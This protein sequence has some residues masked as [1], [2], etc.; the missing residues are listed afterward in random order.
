M[1]NTLTSLR[2]SSKEVRARVRRK[3]P[4][5]RL[6]VEALEAR[7]VPSAVPGSLDVLATRTAAGP[8]GT[9]YYRVDLSAAH[10]LV[11]YF[12]VDSPFSVSDTALANALT[13][14]NSLT[15]SGIDEALERYAAELPDVAV[16]RAGHDKIGKA[17]VKVDGP[18]AVIEPGT[19]PI[20]LPASV[21]IVAVDLRDLPA[22]DE[23]NE[24]LPQMVVPALATPV[25]QLVHLVRTHDGPKDEVFSPFNVYSTNVGQVQPPPLP[26]TGTRDLPIV[27]IVGEQIAPQAAD[28]AATLRAA[29]RAWIA[30]ESVRLEVA[31]SEWQGIGKDGLAVRT[32]TLINVVDQP[33]TVLPNQ[34]AAQDNP[35]DPATATYR[36]DFTIAPGALAVTVSVDGQAT[37]DLDLFLVHD[38][39]GDGIFDLYSEYVAFGA[40]GSA[41]ETVYLASP[42]AGNYEVFVHGYSVPSGTTTFTLAIGMT[43]G[44]PLPDELQPDLAVD[45]ILGSNGTTGDDRYAALAAQIIGVT[46][47]TVAGPVER[48]SPAVVDPFGYIH[49]ESNERGE[50]R[51]ALIAAHGAARRFFPYFPVVGDT[52]D[53]RLIETL[54][55]VDQSDTTDRLEA[56]RILRRFGE[57]LHDGHQFVFNFYG[58]DERQGILPVQLE[59]PD[60]Q[61]RPIVR[62][63]LA[64]GVN[65]GDTIV[66]L[67]GRPIEQVY[68][69]ELART[70]AATPGYQY[71]IADRFIYW[72]TGPMTLTLEDTYGVQR[73]VTVP[74][75]PQEVYFELSD[76]GVSDRANGLLG[77]L[78]APQ[79]FYLNMNGFTTPTGSA[80][81]AAIR[82]ATA[83]GAAGMVLDM[84]GY[85]GVDHYEAAM[86]LIGAPF[87]SPIFNVPTY[88][89]VH[90]FSVSSDQYTL[91]PLGAPRFDGP[92]V[93]LTGP[94]AVSAAENFMQMLVG[95]DRVTVVGQR[96]AG[97]NGNITGI[98]VP[99]GFGFTFTGMEVL[100][101]DGSRFHGIG[102]EPDVYVPITAEDLRDGIDR[103]LLTAIG[104]LGG[105]PAPSSSSS[106]QGASLLSSGS[107]PQS[108]ATGLAS[109]G[110]DFSAASTSLWE[111][112]GAAM[113]NFQPIDDDGFVSLDR[114]D[115]AASHA[116]TELGGSDDDE[117]GGYSDRDFYFVL[118]GR[119]KKDMPADFASAVFGDEM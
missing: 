50:L 63:S 68:A 93:L 38:A 79:L 49:P 77:D 22:I 99:G 33:P 54:G 7:S 27:L 65:P 59:H 9:H 56:W 20:Q 15:H 119:K 8:A 3:K 83:S 88:E 18:L 37:D 44:A 111:H 4:G 113:A 55:L 14:D 105:P 97:T 47:P 95:A 101:P 28:F 34:V 100:N 98:Q 42:L 70:S 6:A 76:R 24:I 53:E 23:L 86:R 71:D 39:N 92:I 104:L 112:A 41:D 64:P 16:L 10:N 81:R 31:E 17:K 110:I 89:G 108:G 58:F 96:S 82:E 109:P 5:I 66:A 85:P 62:H 118:L 21:Q 29:G 2:R 94:H 91:P 57:S 116:S 46:P 30:G 45:L 102:I 117:S 36:H 84:R 107:S 80:L 51:A 19:G 106:N 114:Y 12:S 43:T 103:D 60:N 40:T 25:S 48:T 32:E 61:V 72:M 35:F 13:D 87:H 1:W 74:V 75:V 26:A 69:E 73:T 115:S 67:E 90:N 11:R 78:G 52:I